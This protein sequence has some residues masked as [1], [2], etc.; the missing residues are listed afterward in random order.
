M[1]EIKFPLKLTLYKKGDMI[2]YSQLD[3]FHLL[4][5]ALRR[6]ELPLYFTKGFNPHV[7]IS[8]PYALKLGI[9]GKIEADLYFTKEVSPS[10]VK[11]SLC[12]E[13]PQGLEILDIKKT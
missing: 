4:E 12:V 1:N 6:T 9:E 3:M 2:Y 5:K 13:L 7:K 10:K 11:E 8:F